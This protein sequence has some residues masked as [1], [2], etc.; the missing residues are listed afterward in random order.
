MDGQLAALGLRRTARPL[1]AVFLPHRSTH[2]QQSQ[3]AQHSS[4][5][6]A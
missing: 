1:R 3:W 2:R 5:Q 4:S 6:P